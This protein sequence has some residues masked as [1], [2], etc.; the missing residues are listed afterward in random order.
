MRDRDIFK[1]KQRTV[2]SAKNVHF[3]N[4]NIH[5]NVRSDIQFESRI[6][7][8][9]N[10]YKILESNNTVINSNTSGHGYKSLNNMKKRLTDIQLNAHK[11]IQELESENMKIKKTPIFILE[12]ATPVWR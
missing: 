1:K 8:F 3:R 11:K 9:F 2:Q 5:I 7:L 12:Q 10:N 6:F 4:R